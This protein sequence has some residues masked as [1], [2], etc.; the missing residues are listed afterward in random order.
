MLITNNSSQKL[1]T[2]NIYIQKKLHIKEQT[3]Y[4]PQVREG[5][6]QWY[7]TT[8][9]QFRRTNFQSKMMTQQRA[10]RLKSDHNPSQI[11]L[12]EFL[13]R[14]EDTTTSAAPEVWCG[15]LSQHFLPPASH[16]SSLPQKLSNKIGKGH[17]NHRMVTGVISENKSKLKNSI[18]LDI[19]NVQ[20]QDEQQTKQHIF[21]RK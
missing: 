2:K 1:C 12:H 16:Q 4:K 20:A 7:I 17:V 21:L 15:P 5:A 8:H 9:S 6:K 11:S 13:K 19:A 18:G 14:D 3:M 10:L